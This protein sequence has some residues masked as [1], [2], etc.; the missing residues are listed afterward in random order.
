MISCGLSDRALKELSE[1]ANDPSTRW[2]QPHH[3]PRYKSAAEAVRA[4]AELLYLL[5][6]LPTRPF[7]RSVTVDRIALL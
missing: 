4:F 5:E 3:R 6:T 1:D 2:R 7:K